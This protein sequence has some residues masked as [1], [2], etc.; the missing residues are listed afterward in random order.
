[1]T[2][3]QYPNEVNGSGQ[4]GKGAELEDTQ[5]VDPE[6]AANTSLSSDPSPAPWMF[7]KPPNNAMK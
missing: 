7:F 4:T 3:N 2:H 6:R 5:E 1:M